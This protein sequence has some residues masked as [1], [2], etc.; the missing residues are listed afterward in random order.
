M[1]HYMVL[2]RECLR[3]PFFFASARR[4]KGMLKPVRTRE[5]GQTAYG[6]Q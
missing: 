2:N 5:K 3:T 6:R 1:P 4:Q